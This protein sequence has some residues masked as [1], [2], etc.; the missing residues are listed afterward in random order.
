MGPEHKN[1]AGWVEG[2]DSG[3][4]SQ[5]PK[6]PPNSASRARRRASRTRRRGQR[7]RVLW[8]PASDGGGFGTT[9]GLS[10]RRAQ[11]RGAGAERQQQQHW[12]NVNNTGGS[13]FL[14][15]PAGM[16]GGAR[17]PI[18]DR[19]PESVAK[20]SV[21]D[22]TITDDCGRYTGLGAPHTARLKGQHAC[23][24]S[25]SP[26]GGGEPRRV[27]QIGNVTRCTQ[28]T[29]YA[30]CWSRARPRLLRGTG[31]ATGA[32]WCLKGAVGQGMRTHVGAYQMQRTSCFS[33]YITGFA[34]TLSS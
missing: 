6:K 9:S 16:W 20:A 17:H 15:P 11:A 25:H 32:G 22:D 29:R 30:A 10:I 23:G 31:T 4:G 21:D 2:D 24:A 5:C 1:L 27:Q 18:C 13:G 28:Q 26:P 3:N 34:P 12:L 14:P 7:R 33:A 8:L 19:L